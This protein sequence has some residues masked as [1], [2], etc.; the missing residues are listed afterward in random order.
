NNTTPK[1]T[2]PRNGTGCC[3]DTEYWSTCF[4][5]LSHG[6]WGIRCDEL[7]IGCVPNYV[8]GAPDRLER[9]DQS[10]A[11]YVNRAMYS[12]H[13]FFESFSE[14][15]GRGVFLNAN[16]QEIRSLYFDINSDEIAEVPTLL[17][18]L[19]IPL[20]LGFTETAP[21][22]LLSNQLTDWNN[23]EIAPIA[24]LWSSAIRAA[25]KVQEVLWGGER[26]ANAQQQSLQANWSI[27]HIFGPST[28]ELFQKALTQIMSDIHS[29]LAF[30]AEGRFVSGNSSALP[31]DLDLAAG[32]KTFVLSKLMQMDNMYAVHG[33][34][35]NETTYTE[36]VAA[37]AG[38]ASYWS[39]STRRQY[40]LRAKGNT[41]IEPRTLLD[42]LARGLVD[43]QLLFD[44]TYNCTAAGWAGGS[45]VNRVGEVGGGDVACLSQ[46]P[47]YL[48]KGAQCPTDVFV[49]GKCPF[50]YLG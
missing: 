10:Q 40:E 15:L 14:Q 46:L 49:G 31:L 25:P 34:I 30:A 8:L 28:K 38:S 36:F 24:R 20:T 2:D 17:D 9:E 12:I 27:G 3:G 42:R 39:P 48:E 18:Q 1:C 41:K 32:A 37:N 6:F 33:P 7:G 45:I 19:S 47:L 11:F 35:V 23:P 4:L 13:Q 5:R 44:G 50:G 26:D 21:A 22:N 16:L 43:P 29:F